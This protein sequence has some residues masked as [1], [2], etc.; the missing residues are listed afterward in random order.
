MIRFITNTYPIFIEANLVEE[1]RGGGLGK[2]MK[3]IPRSPK[4]DIRYETTIQF[5]FEFCNEYNKNV[6]KLHIKN[7]HV[8]CGLT[9]IFHAENKSLMN[10]VNLVSFIF[11]GEILFCLISDM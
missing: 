9:S 11:G 2:K 5:E 1:G 4:E 10:Y 6:Q 7:M 3:P 8:D